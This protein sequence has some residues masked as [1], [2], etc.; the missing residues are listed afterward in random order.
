MISTFNDLFRTIA[1]DVVWVVFGTVAT[2]S[3][4]ISGVNFLTAMGNAQKLAQARQ[5]FLWGMVGVVVGVVA[6]SA[7]SLISKA[8][9]G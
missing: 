4:I 6:Y 9:G 7:I 8:L 1:T 2:V 3:F 5:A